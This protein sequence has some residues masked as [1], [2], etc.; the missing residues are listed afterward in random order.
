MR[1]RQ[2]LL[3]SF[4]F[5]LFF[6]ASLFAQNH[7]NI[8]LISQTCEFWSDIEDIVISENFAYVAANVSGLQILDLSDPLRPVVIGY[9]KQDRMIAKC[10]F[11]SEN[12]VYI[13]HRTGVC[14]VDVSDPENPEFIGNCNSDLLVCDVTVDEGI[15]YFVAEDP[16]PMMIGGLFIYDSSDPAD[17]VFLSEWTIPRD[18]VLVEKIG[19]YIYIIDDQ[20][21]TIGMHVV[22]VTDPRAPR[23]VRFWETDGFENGFEVVG[24]RAYIAANRD[25]DGR[26][27]PMLFSI[28]VSEPGRPV[29]VDSI[30]CG[31]I[32]DI[33]SIN[34]YLFVTSQTSD[35][36]YL[37]AVDIFNNEQFAVAASILL[38]HDAGKLAVID[39]F[40]YTGDSELG[41]HIMDISDPFD[42]S[43]AGVFE[44]AGSNRSATLCGDLIYISGMG[45]RIADIEDPTS[46]VYSRIDTEMEFRKMSIVEEKGCGLWNNR[47]G[48]TFFDC[49]DPLQPEPTRYIRY[50]GD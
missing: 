20:P 11:L 50:G 31:R 27:T 29:A 44:T 35:R 25:R 21:F 12:I 45:F 39:G 17:P 9:Y 36:A 40:A 37:R 6:S 30:V 4:I 5:L 7:E 15:V 48:V 3:L 22:N 46:P 28:D 14:M 19:N 42:M 47:Y 41:I 23:L 33:E 18:A 8:E 49:S 16:N 32:T 26:C 2:P 1:F 24:D 10:L 13:G 43:D 38:D 34:G